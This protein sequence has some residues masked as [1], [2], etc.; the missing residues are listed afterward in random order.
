MSSACPEMEPHKKPSK[1]VVCALEIVDANEGTKDG[2]IT[3]LESFVK[4]LK[5][6]D[7]KPIVSELKNTPVFL[8]IVLLRKAVV[9]DQ[10][11]CKNIRGARRIRQP[12]RRVLE[13]LQWAKESPGIVKPLL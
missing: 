10:L 7:A 1:A 3:V 6:K 8:F 13:R 11:T 5:K 12:E 2:T 4:D 9:G